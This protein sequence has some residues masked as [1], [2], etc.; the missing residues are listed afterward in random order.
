M[1]SSISH[2]RLLRDKKLYEYLIKKRVGLPSL[3]EE[4]KDSVV[5]CSSNL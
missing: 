1:V 3:P 2:I 5:S 4:I